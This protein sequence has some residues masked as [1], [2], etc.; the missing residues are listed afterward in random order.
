M[1]H[2]LID[3]AD[4]GEIPR[5]PGE[6]RTVI[7]RIDTGGEET[8]NLRA[9]RDAI[10]AATGRMRYSDVVPE[11]LVTGHGYDVEAHSGPIIDLVDT[12]TSTS[13]TTWRAHRSPA[14]A[15]EAEGRPGGDGRQHLRRAGRRPARAAVARRCAGHGAFPLP[16]QGQ[17]GVPAG[18]VD[19]RAR[20]SG[21][22]LRA[23]PGRSG[24][25][26]VTAIETRRAS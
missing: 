1:T 15:A 18:L 21:R 26:P 13:P 17:V 10:L 19:R 23:G 8:K 2:T 12:A 5:L 6:D 14:A 22:V 25:G 11:S 16:P 24:G 4:S 3:H 7:I 9:E 20:G